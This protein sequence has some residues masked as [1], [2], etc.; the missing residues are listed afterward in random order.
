MARHELQPDE[1]VLWEGRYYGLQGKRVKFP[2][3]TKNV[4]TN[5]RLIH[6]HLGKMAPLYNGL[7]FLLRLLVKGKPISL[8]LDGMMVSRGKYVKNN[9]LLSLQTAD[10]TQVLLNNFEK[11]LDWFRSTLEA[12]GIS[13]SPLGEEE[14]QVKV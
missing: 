10:G 1:K 2:V 9:K 11:S 13:L 4:I 5:R 14:W 3:S 7:G 6:Y 8:P 12:S